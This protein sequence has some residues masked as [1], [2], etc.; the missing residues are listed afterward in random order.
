M[1]M[2]QT[3]RGNSGFAAEA[4][5]RLG[6]PR[7]AAVAA[8]AGHTGSG[9][10]LDIADKAAGSLLGTLAVVQNDQMAE[11]ACQSAVGRVVPNH[12]T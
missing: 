6:S 11:R 10:R 9:T 3:Q 8:A 2:G 12:K 5:S 7:I 4:G 1:R